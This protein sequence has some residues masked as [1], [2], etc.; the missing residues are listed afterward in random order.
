VRWLV[1]LIVALGAGCEPPGYGRH[2]VDAG[3]D[4]TRDGAKSPD[5]AFDSGATTCTQTFSLDGHGGAASVDLTGDFA[6]WGGDPAHGATALALVG[7]TWTGMRDFPAGTYQY[8]FVVDGTMWIPD[9]NNPNSVPD[10]F[11][12]HNSVYDCMP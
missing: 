5:A 12:G 2:N 3:T 7:S 11:G 1:V 6:A 9:P 4:G 10:G 8:K